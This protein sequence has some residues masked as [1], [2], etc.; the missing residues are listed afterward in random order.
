MVHL[1]GGVQRHQPRRLHLGRRVGDPALHRLLVLQQ[2]ALDGAVERALAHH[3]EGA[4][5]HPEPAHAVV[6][7]TRDEAVLGDQ[8]PVA[9]LPEQRVGAEPDVLVADLGVA[10]EH[11][12]VLVRLLHVGD[13][14]HEVDTG[15][16]DRDEEHRGALVRRRVGVGDRHHDEEVGDRAVRGEPLV[17]V[18]DV[19]VAVADCAGPELGRIRAG[20]V[21]LGHRERG[22]DLAVEQRVE[23]ALLLLVGARE[24][25][26]LA[27][28]RVGC[29]AA[30]H[31][32]RV[33]RRAEDLVHQPELDLPEAL[34]AELRREVRSPQ[35]PLP[36]P[37]LERRADPVELRLGD[38]V[39][40]RLDRPDLSRTNARIHSSCSLELRLGREIPGH[41]C[42][43]P[44]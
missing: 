34:A 43:T 21:G 29:L 37:L 26:D 27:V 44:F 32:W 11:A 38:L 42:T 39:R 9:L 12:V 7:P 24:R 13:V 3:V 6:D 5:R 18:E 2:A 36:H 17:P 1:P 28:T 14:A 25:D 40:D 8:E 4:P 22:P 33:D 20:G 23:P 41:G 10:A 19:A 16:V 31:G 15:R 35:A 30:E